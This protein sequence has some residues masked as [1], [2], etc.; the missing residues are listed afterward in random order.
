MVFLE[1]R[2][3]SY[4]L[5]HTFSVDIHDLW[6]LSWKENSLASLSYCNTKYWNI[7][8]MDNRPPVIEQLEREPLRLRSR[9]GQWIDFESKSDF[10][11]KMILF[12]K[13]SVNW[14]CTARLTSSSSH[15]VKLHFVNKRF[16]Y[17]LHF[18]PKSEICLY[19]SLKIKIR[20]LKQFTPL[21]FFVILPKN[22]IFREN[23]C[24]FLFVQNGPALVWSRNVK[25][26]V[27]S[28]W[29]GARWVGQSGLWFTWSGGD[30]VETLA[31][32]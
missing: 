29:V 22:L 20:C 1:I 18:I 24:H 8:R 31:V 3:V 14:F 32:N 4:W 15:L 13:K 7:S 28:E 21:F 25:V 5:L 27:E 10:S 23:N 11:V 17:W 26:L 30:M 9:A 2:C 19:F 16:G 12:S 6:W